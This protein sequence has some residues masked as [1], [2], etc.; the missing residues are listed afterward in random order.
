MGLLSWLF[1]APNSLLVRQVAELTHELRHLQQD[2]EL[3]E[4]K[5][6][7]LQGKVNQSHRKPKKRDDEE[8]EEEG[9]YTK[10]ELDFIKSTAEYQM[11]AS[12]QAAQRANQ[13]N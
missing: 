6:G 2:M 5:F 9:E 12:S 13:K 3:L 10:D 7:S 4:T 8:E 1:G 11:L